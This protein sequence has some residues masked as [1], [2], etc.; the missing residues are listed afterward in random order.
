MIFNEP[1]VELRQGW[2]LEQYLVQYKNFV[3]KN[4]KD[5]LD[6]ECSNYFAKTSLHWKKMKYAFSGNFKHFQLMNECQR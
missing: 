4:Y 2:I 6:P 1:C 5:R 3:T